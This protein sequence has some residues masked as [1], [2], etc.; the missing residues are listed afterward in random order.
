MDNLILP[1]RVFIVLY[2][3]MVITILL[4][5]QTYI[6]YHQIDNVA[7]NSRKEEI[8]KFYRKLKT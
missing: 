8:I 1:I 3:L 7:C 2:V 4:L 5:E 6:L